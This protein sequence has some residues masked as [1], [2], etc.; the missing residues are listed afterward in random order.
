MSKVFLR[1]QMF[2]FK[3]EKLPLSVKDLDVSKLGEVRIV[4]GTGKH[5]T[6][7]IIDEHSH[8]GGSGQ[9]NE[10]TQASTAE[11]RIGDILNPDDVDIYRQM[12][13]GTTTTQILHGSANPIGGQSAL[14]KL[15]WG[16]CSGRHE[17]RY[18]GWFHQVRLG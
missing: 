10:G 4:D 7:G 8:V 6:P 5:L 1:I 9:I 11:V 12:S 3:M 14:V 18:Q 17:N 2:Y 16:G 15:R 13:M